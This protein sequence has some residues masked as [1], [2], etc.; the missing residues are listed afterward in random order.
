MNSPGAQY[1]KGEG[2]RNIYEKN[3]EMEPKQKQRTVVY[4]FANRSQVR[5]CKEQYCLGTWNNLGS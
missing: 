1:A 5:C 2:Q 4:M 3:K